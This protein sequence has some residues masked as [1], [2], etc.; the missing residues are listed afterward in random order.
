[1]AFHRI[2]VL[3][4]LPPSGDQARR[5]G[6]RVGSISP[7]GAPRTPRS[8][9]AASR[10]RDDC[11]VTERRCPP[12]SARPKQSFE[13]DRTRQSRRRL[14]WRRST[15]TPGVLYDALDAQTLDPAARAFASDHVVVHSALFGLVGAADP[16]PAY[17][18]SHNSRLPDLALRS[19]WR[20]AVSTVLA[21]QEGLI[22]DLHPEAYGSQT[23]PDSLGRDAFVARRGRRGRT[24]GRVPSTTS[25][26]KKGKGRFV[27]RLIEAG[28]DHDPVESLLDWATASGIS[29]AREGES[30][31]RTRG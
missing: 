27:R 14:P 31:T 2:V 19:T 22:I 20:D 6:R 3:V 9:W 28:I 11:P 12:P 29:L 15:G 21:R 16:I 4:L 23:R 7:A 30:G 13:V 1:M 25:S 8:R 24:V 10:P 18:L 26:N 5:R 17:R